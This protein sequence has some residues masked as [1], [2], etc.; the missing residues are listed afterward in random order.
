MA[1]E[2]SIMDEVSLEEMEENLKEMEE[3]GIVENGENAIE[4]EEDL[5]KKVEALE[6]ERG[7]LTAEVLA[8]DEL[9]SKLEKEVNSLKG[10]FIS[11]NS[12]KIQPKSSQYAVKIQSKFSQ[13]SVKIQPKFS[14]NPAKIQ[15]IFSQYSVKI[16]S[17]FSQNSVKIFLKCL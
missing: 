3:N 8:K 17:K 9:I 4:I 12:V 7:Q 6:S 10:I 14:Q 11:Y 16:Q 1:E 13:N 2:S 15:S 5:S